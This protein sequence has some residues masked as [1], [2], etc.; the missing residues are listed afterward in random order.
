MK[1][2]LVILIGLLLAVSCRDVGD[3][4]GTGGQN[5]LSECVL[6]SSVQAGEDAL[7]QW[8][9]FNKEA[10][11][12]LVSEDGQEYEVQ[13]KVLTD[14]G[15]MFVVP[16]GLPAGTYS[17]VLDQDGRKRLGTFEVLAA[18]MPIT[19][20]S[21]PSKAVIG[22]ELLIDGIGFE[23]GCS[24]L[25]VDASGNEYEAEATLVPSGISV[26]LPGDIKK[27][28]YEVYL[29]QDGAV[30]LISS[31]FTVYKKGG[32]QTLMR[33]DY[34][35]PY[36]NSSKLKLSWEINREDPITLTLSEYLVEGEEETLQA[37]DQYVCDATGTFKLTHDG[38]ESSNDLTMAYTRNADGIVTVAD[39]KI[40]GKSSTTPFSWAYDADGYLTEISSPA[41]S[42]R[43][44][45]YT[46]GNLTTFR[47]SSFTY[48]D[49]ELVNHPSAPDVVWAY[50]AMMESNDPFVYI[51][52]LLGWYAKASAQL[53]TMMVLPS[54]TGTGT[55]KSPLTYTFDDEGY[56]VKMAWESSEIDFIFE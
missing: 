42:F 52:Y 38:F 2:I 35:S 47:N 25:L 31:S 33:L 4:N 55:T 30:W 37:Y 12:W 11:I 20:L 1:R 49:P 41:N 13:I 7:V 22:E 24:L 48:E 28:G 23:E 14:S 26:M 8:N 19:G 3:L 27:G 45:E 17:L 10:K 34:Y 15:I 56:V 9:G 50:M 54:P 6:P 16:A 39:V 29:V 36:L 44:L 32:V 53:P 51:P 18:D 5:Y 21:V 40:Y 46:D 43:S